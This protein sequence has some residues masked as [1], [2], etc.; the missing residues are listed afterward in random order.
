MR[1]SIW[2]KNVGRNI[3]CSDVT[4]FLTEF[5]VTNSELE[6]NILCRCHNLRWKG[7][8][9]TEIII[10]QHIP[11]RKL[12]T[13]DCILRD[14]NGL[15]HLICAPTLSRIIEFFGGFNSLEAENLRG[16]LS[17]G[18]SMVEFLGEHQSKACP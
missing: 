13:C 1:G 11:F 9:L 4:K 17:R 7:V 15:F 12:V 18:V 3:A 8:K 16:F 5:I 2:I 10:D 14:V 6:L